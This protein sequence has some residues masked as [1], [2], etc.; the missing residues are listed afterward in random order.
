MPGG[1]ERLLILHPVEHLHAYSIPVDIPVSVTSNNIP[2][3]KI[4]TKL[5]GKRL[6]NTIRAII[7][8]SGQF[9][10]PNRRHQRREFTSTGTRIMYRDSAVVR[11]RGRMESFL[12]NS[13]W[14]HDLPSPGSGCAFF[15]NEDDTIGDVSH[16]SV[17]H[18]GSSVSEISFGSFSVDQDDLDSLQRETLIE[19]FVDLLESGDSKNLPVSVKVMVAIFYIFVLLCFSTM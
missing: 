12:W 11:Q 6:E 7:L 18:Q 16:T 19:N 13:D 1:G 8:D 5:S 4:S 2:V 14:K 17:G 9:Y 10:N 3:S 15:P